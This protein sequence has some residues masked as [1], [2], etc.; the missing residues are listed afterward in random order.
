MTANSVESRMTAIDDAWLATT[1]EEILEPDLPIVDPHHHLWDFPFHR[2]L[3]HELL[4]DT[5]SGHNVR[6]TVFIECGAMYRGG[7]PKAEAPVGEVEFVNGTAAMSA[8]G[9]YGETA[10]CAGIVG[11]ADLTL[12]AAAED[13]LQA[14]I[15]AGNGRFRGI[16]HAAGYDPSPD[17][18]NSHTN[19]PPGLFREAA[20]R[21]GF[22]RL[23]ALDLTFEAWLYHTQLEDVVGLASA[24]PNARIVLNHVGG[25]LGIGPYAGRHDEIFPGW[26]AGIRAIAACENVHVKLGGLGMKVYGFDFHK[27]DRAPDSDTLAAVWKPYID[28]CIEAFGPSRCMFESNFPVDKASCSYAVMWNAFKKLAAG[29]SDGEKADLFAGTARRF[30]K[31]DGV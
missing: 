29:A 25:P 11:F 20:F 3:L 4:E 21:E 15:A 2:Y 5:G 19:P 23:A 6:A 1:E 27:Q 9:R 17:V 13:V 28:T 26:Q 8:S 14:E 18:R 24:F 12:G 22:A 30:Y 16:R 7:G 10:A 31:L